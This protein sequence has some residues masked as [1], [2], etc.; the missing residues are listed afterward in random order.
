MVTHLLLSVDIQF[1]ICVVK[2]IILIFLL[3]IVLLPIF[4]LGMTGFVPGLSAVLGTDKPRDLGIKYSQANLQSIRSK[5]QVKYETL[6]DSPVPMQT[7]QFIGS[8]NYTGEFSA[9]EITATINN[10][11]WKY[12]PYKNVQV[13]FNADGSGEISGILIKD[14]VPAYASTLGLPSEVIQFAMKYLPGDPVFYVKMKAAL[15][16]NKVSL[17]EPQKFEIG[18][19]SM[20]LELFL[21]FGGQNIIPEVYAQDINSMSRELS[22]VNNKKALIIDYINSRLSSAFG[23]FYAKKAYF[24]ENKVYFDGTL[25]QKIQYTP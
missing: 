17:F 6:P 4:G 18:R 19:I 3:I 1:I 7:R 20:P 16:D 8:R 14:K 23:S 21:S 9:E 2:K 12:W 10:Q 13:K 22:K 15:T 11:P 5:S 24:G 25:S